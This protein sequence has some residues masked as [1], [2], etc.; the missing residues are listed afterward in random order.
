MQSFLFVSTSVSDFLFVCHSCSELEVVNVI[1]FFP[2]LHLGF[3]MVF[4]DDRISGVQFI[5]RQSFLF[6]ST[7]VSDLNF[8]FLCAILV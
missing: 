2:V 8:I 7:S 5:D 3:L 4:F 1:D 6:V